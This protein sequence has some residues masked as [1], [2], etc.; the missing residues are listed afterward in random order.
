M[1][2]PKT[3][4]SIHDSKSPMR[5]LK[6]KKSKKR[7]CTP[8]YSPKLFEREKNLFHFYPN[9]DKKSNENMLF[10][11][12]RLDNE[13][14]IN[15]RLS[16]EDIS[17]NNNFNNV[18][19]NYPCN[20][21]PIEPPKKKFISLIEDSLNE[22]TDN[23]YGLLCSQITPDTVFKTI[24]SDEQK[25]KQHNLKEHTSNEGIFSAI[26]QIILNLKRKNFGEFVKMVKLVK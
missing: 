9:T 18:N 23:Y 8:A 15:Q 24:F 26:N 4:K 1:T 7:E 14:K 19:S 5:R 2:T 12:E 16:F 21:L 22:V 20:N 13:Y 10:K 11:E 3:N 25:E 17:C 6:L